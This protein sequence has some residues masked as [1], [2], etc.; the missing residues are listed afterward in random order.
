MKRLPFILRGKGRYAV[1]I[2][3]SIVFVVSGVAYYAWMN[4]IVPEELL[5]QV[6]DKALSATRYRYEVLLK[7]DLDGKQRVL[8]HVKGERV[9]KQFHIFGLIAGQEVDVYFINDKLYMKDAVSERWMIS[10][11]GG[12]FNGDLF[13]VEVDPLASLE[14][15]GIGLIEYLGIEQNK[16]R[17]HV[18]DY[19]P[20]VVNKMLTS[21]WSDFKYRIWIDRK[22]KELIKVRITGRHHDKPENGLLMEFVATD[23]NKSIRLEAPTG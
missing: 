9:G 3:L 12:L 7:L 1:L 14:H 16:R 6:I 4:T 19:A 15:Q 10:H 21:Y 20:V 13:M 5:P 11:G 17:A 2:L 18:M 23:F 8:S 22:T